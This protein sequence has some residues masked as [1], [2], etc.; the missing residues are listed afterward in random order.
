MMKSPYKI[1][2]FMGA[3]CKSEELNMAVS[4]SELKKAMDTLGISDIHIDKEQAKKIYKKLLLKWHPDACM[5][6]EE[7]FYNEACAKINAAYEVIEKAYEEGLMGPKAQTTKKDS[8]TYKSSSSCTAVYSS[9]KSNSANKANYSRENTS[10]KST[11]TKQNDDSK[12]SNSDYEEQYTFFDNFDSADGLDIVYFRKRW[13]NI[14]FL[15]ICIIYICNAI[16]KSPMT[17]IYIEK[18]IINL[19]IMVAAYY[20]IYWSCKGLAAGVGFIV[21]GI[22]A[23]LIFKGTT[24]ISMSVYNKFGANFEWLAMLLFIIAFFAAEYFI[25]IKRILIT[26]DKKIKVKKHTVIF[27]Y[28]MLLEYGIMLAFGIYSVILVH[29]FI[30]IRNTIIPPWYH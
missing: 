18:S 14:I 26:V 19:I 29:K 2:K 28:I 6:G 3:K 10:S 17:D 21:S 15:T 30:S 22:I 13:L 4:T 25:H 23:L 11:Y 27:S 12:S 7:Q 9:S 5:N 16:I 8:Y 1:C 24:A 20:A